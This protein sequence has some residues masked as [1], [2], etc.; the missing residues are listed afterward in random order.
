MTRLFDEILYVG[1]DRSGKEFNLPWVRG[2]LDGLLAVL[3]PRELVRR[4]VG[5]LGAHRRHSD[6]RLHAVLSAETIANNPQLENFLRS[7]ELC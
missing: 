6:R 4:D 7:E 1:D 3:P 2:S 5:D